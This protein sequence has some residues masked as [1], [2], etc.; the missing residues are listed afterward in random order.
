MDPLEDDR[1]TSAEDD[2][3]E[4]ETEGLILLQLVARQAMDSMNIRFFNIFSTLR[5]TGPKT[6]GPTLA[7]PRKRGLFFRNPFARNKKILGRGQR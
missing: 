3:A 2:A 4:W 5:T 7:V 1:V 6:V